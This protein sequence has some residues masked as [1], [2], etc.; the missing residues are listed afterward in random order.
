MSHWA[1][2][3]EAWRHTQYPL[4]PDPSEVEIFRQQLIAKP[5]D[6]LLLGVT[7][8][9]A[10]LAASGIRIRAVDSS[11]HMIASVWPGDTVHRT[12]VCGNWF[13]LPTQAAWADFIMGDGVLT[14]LPR[15]KHQDFLSGLT[16]ALASRG[17]IILRAFA[18]PTVKP[19][20]E[21]VLHSASGITFSNFKWRLATALC[22]ETHTV[23]VSLLYRAF[24]QL[25]SEEDIA[26]LGWT[27]GMLSTIEVYEDSP[28]VYSFL[29]MSEYWA[30]FADC[31]LKVTEMYQ[32]ASKYLPECP[33]FVVERT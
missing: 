33:I 19:T 18:S 24:R 28:E 31:G 3:Q 9:L 32:G 7:P 12:A 17:R 29:T 14:V 23:P 11:P 30:T 6:V 1:R 27:P 13:K 21:E 10:E 16:R 26:R 20:L 4:K 15:S 5:G 22:G 2:M 8:A 25:V